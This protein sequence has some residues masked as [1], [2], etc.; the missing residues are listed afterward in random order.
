MA[1]ATQHNEPNHDLQ[2]EGN[3]SGADKISKLE[4]TLSSP[5]VKQNG[6]EKETQKDA[7]TIDINNTSA[8]TAP[9]PTAIDE[10]PSEK[11]KPVTPADKSYSSFS[12]V[13]KLLITIMASWPAF[14]SPLSANIYYPIFNI[15]ADDFKVSNTLINLTV[16]VYMIMQGL[17]PTFIA[18]LSDGAGRRPAFAVSFIIYL[19]ANIGLALQSNYAAL[20]V[21]RLLQSAGSSSTI[22]LGNAIVADIATTAERGVFIS[23]VSSG[24]FLGP[25]VGPIIGG[26]LAHYLGWRS[27]F[28]FLVISS[29]VVLI[30]ILLFYPETCRK[31]VGDGSI[32]PAPWNMS[33]ITYYHTRKQA[34]AGESSPKRNPIK[35]QNP[36]QTLVVIFEKEVGLVLFATSISFASYYAIISSVPSQFLEIYGY[37][38]VQI[39][40]CFIPVGVAALIAIFSQ[41]K[42]VDFNYK[43]HAL[44][45]GMPVVKSKQTDLSKFPIEQAR[46]EVALPMFSIQAASTIG[47][48]WVTHFNKNLSA[49]LIFLF[50]LTYSAASAFTILSILVVD[51]YPEG[52]GT[53]SAANNLVR[54]WVGAGATVAII[55]MIN[56]MGRGW[57][58][59]LFGF[60]CL[61]FSPILLAVMKWGPGW[62]ETK[63]IKA[64]EK[65]ARK[66][67]S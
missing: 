53:A 45:L 39:G 51:L 48:G 61:G 43:R 20:L 38:D 25:G 24:Q 13:Q 41:G 34:K 46:L 47:Y 67:K 29:G 1:T 62:R 56:A 54:C 49:P 37:N 12:Y 60:L 26:L 2:V 3:N 50:V 6:H 55:P 7:T 44:R 27:V 33:I 28:W 59:T 35:I 18:G 9:A 32:R 31:I 63:R 21:L 64:Q 15:L 66:S 16:T 57:S 36:L 30:V 40:L 11:T 5:T 65:A 17:A 58:A 42:I 19:G 22:A 14:F 10:P 4:E 52:P 8:T 23:W